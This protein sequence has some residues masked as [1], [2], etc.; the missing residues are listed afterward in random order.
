M[1]W[2]KCGGRWIKCSGKTTHMVPGYISAFKTAAYS[3]LRT[4]PLRLFLGALF[5]SG[6]ITIINKPR[7]KWHRTILLNPL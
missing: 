6:A 4:F 5:W 1:A 3:A 2:M 7:S